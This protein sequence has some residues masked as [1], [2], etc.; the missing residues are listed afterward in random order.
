MTS[1][2]RAVWRILRAASFKPFHIRRQVPMGRYFAD[3]LSHRAR[4][5]IEIDGDTHDSGK[6]R[7]R[8]MWF[9]SQGY[10]TLRFWNVDVY[11]SLEGVGDVIFEALQ[12]RCR[13]HPDPPQ[14]GEGDFEPVEC[15]AQS[16]SGLSPPQNG[17]G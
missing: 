7:A 5:V 13:P 11:E 4:L 2:E 6:D 9:L 12:A 10:E 8:D 15:C 16:A 17:E 14:N 3:F 1:A